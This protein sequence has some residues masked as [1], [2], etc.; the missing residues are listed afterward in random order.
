MGNENYEMEDVVESRTYKITLA[1]GTVISDLRLN[2]NNFVSKS[3]ISETKFDGNL[4][5]VIINDGEVDE[6]HGPMALVQVTKM[7]DEYWFILRDLSKN[8]LEM[9]Q[10]RANI[11]YISMMTEVDL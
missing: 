11:D 5:E 2:G 3:R 8:E 10:I 1:D 4:S 9:A 6:I 7:G